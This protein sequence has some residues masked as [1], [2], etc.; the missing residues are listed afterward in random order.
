MADP[1][2]AMSVDPDPLCDSPDLQAVQEKKEK[3]LWIT[4]E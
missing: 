2:L 4:C 3:E 1:D